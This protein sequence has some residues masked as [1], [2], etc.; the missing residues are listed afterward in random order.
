M[1]ESNVNTG[2]VKVLFSTIIL[3][4]A[5]VKKKHFDHLATNQR[6]EQN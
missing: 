4:Q 5:K 3:A 1:A 6:A 2:N